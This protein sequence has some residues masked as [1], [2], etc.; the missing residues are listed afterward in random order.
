MFLAG[1]DKNQIRWPWS[2]S[3]A[4]PL[5][6]SMLS[7]TKSYILVNVRND[8]SSIIKIAFLIPQSKW[9]V[10]SRR[11]L[12]VKHFTWIFSYLI[13]VFAIFKHI[14]SFIFLLIKSSTKTTSFR[15]NILILF[16][17]SKINNFFLGIG[18]FYRFII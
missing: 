1:N 7:I 17:F 6:I 12:V 8:V 18:Y 14:F 3:M 5:K 15:N 10:F 9:S 4:F 11:N 16:N 2:T 13:L